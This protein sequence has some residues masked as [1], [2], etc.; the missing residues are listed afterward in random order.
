MVQLHEAPIRPLDVILFRGVDFVSRAICFME[1]KA[2]GR[3]DYS[4]AGLAITR[5]V[6]DLP[7]LEPGRI[8]VWESTFSAPAGFFARFTDKAPDLETH[9]VRFG[10]QIRDLDLVVPGYAASGGE[11]AWCA[12][13]GT[14]PPIEA[15]RPHL[16]ALH[17]EYGHV[18]YTRNVLDL[19]GVVYPALRPARDHLA[20]MEDRLAHFLNEVLPRARIHVRLEDSEHHLFCS[21]WVGIVY[22]RLGLTPST[23]N[24]HQAAPVSPLLH[25][26]LFAEPVILEPRKNAAT[27]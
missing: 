5:E 3:G 17:Q 21:E 6:L 11:V 23:A 13:R 15:V 24:P 8:Y 12:L 22:K 27:S 14:R 25:P 18:P 19:F 7:F 9:G 4:H 20:R 26:E 16:H 1:A 2:L 10:V